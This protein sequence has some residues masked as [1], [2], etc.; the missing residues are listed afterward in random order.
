MIY[1]A[2]KYSTKIGNS[3]IVT[4]YFIPIHHKLMVRFEQMCINYCNEKI[5][6]MFN[7]R[8]FE[9]EIAR[10]VEEGIPVDG[11]AYETCTDCLSLLEGESG[12]FKL[13]D[14]FC[15]LGKKNEED[16][17]LLD[18]IDKT[19]M[20]TNPR[21]VGRKS[22][23]AA[24]F[25]AMRSDTFVIKHFAG[26]AMYS[27][28]GF[29]AANGDKLE[30]D[31]SDVI[32]SSDSVI[33]QQFY[34]VQSIMNNAK[35]REEE[36][37]SGKR[38]RHNVKKVTI[39]AKFRENLKT[40]ITELESTNTQFLRCIKP[41]QEKSPDL[42]DAPLVYSQLRYSGV[43]GVVAIRKCSFPLRQTWSD[44]HQR[45]VTLKLYKG[46]SEISL[47]GEHSWG[48]AQQEQAAKQLFKLVFPESSGD[49]YSGKSIVYMKQN[50][51]EKISDFFST[52][53]VICIQQ[54]WRGV[55]TR[56]RISKIRNAIIKLQRLW[57][58]KCFRAKRMASVILC[59]SFFRMSRA[60]MVVSM[61]RRIREVSYLLNRWKTRARIR[62]RRY[63]T[64]IRLFLLR[65]SWRLPI[66]RLPPAH[67]A[68]TRWF[69]S[70]LTRLDY[71][72]LKSAVT[73]ISAWYR[74]RSTYY[75]YRVE[76]IELRVIYQDRLEKQS[77]LKLTR[78][79]S[80][81]QYVPNAVE[82]N[83]S[84][85]LRFFRTLCFRHFCTTLFANVKVHIIHDPACLSIY[86]MCAIGWT[87]S[88]CEVAT[89]PNQK[90]RCV[91][92][93]S[94]YCGK[95]GVWGYCYERTRLCFDNGDVEHWSTQ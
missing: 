46:V 89:P 1:S 58:Q 37:S 17:P 74:G 62:K 14:E 49:Y 65:P 44:I 81:F 84:S 23:A 12:I 21:Y 38:R 27:I 88:P 11:I 93:T 19:L 28:H 75:V 69:R 2:L 6:A 90:T 4:T 78:F 26:D 82:F 63:A 51:Y 5:Q 61:L 42:F 10:L 24:K 76:I 66:S 15:F 70:K 91:R 79:G 47:S 92:S 20:S 30:N 86:R 22:K 56:Q 25:P 18:I 45:L 68:L 32:R 95:C 60:K 16:L 72:K 41:N 52:K 77:A 59:Q 85:L 71:L 50:I 54:R 39:S 53:S 43:I 31:L 34:E 73:R 36:A 35:R 40:L 94:P 48:C 83:L 64:L 87:C 57:W 80:M 9:S 7:T 55:I 67:N 29:I 8:I 13:T 3:G 33:I